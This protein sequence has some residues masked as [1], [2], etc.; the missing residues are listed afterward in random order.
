MADDKRLE[1]IEDKID[2]LSTHLGSIDTTLAGQHVQLSE[3]IRRTAILE[4]TIKPIKEHVDMVKGAIKLIAI[5]AA[6]VAFAESLKML[7]GS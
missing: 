7:I 1:R 4:E 2:N 5:I 6:I 3:H